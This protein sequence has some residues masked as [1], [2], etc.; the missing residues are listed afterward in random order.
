VKI[1]LIA[2]VLVL[3]FVAGGVVWIGMPRG[4]SLEEVSHLAAPSIERMDAQKVLLVRA[5]GNPNEV[6]KEA[7]GLL[8]KTYYGLPDVPKGGPELQPPRARWPVGEDVAMEDWEGLYAMPVPETVTQ[9]PEGTASGGLTVELAT[10]EYGEVA[11][12]LHVG[13]YDQEE[14]TVD[15]LKAFIESQGYQIS[16]LHEEEYLKGPGMLFMGN[17]DKYLTL[18]RYPV[19]RAGGEGS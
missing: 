1:L 14:E 15:R 4:P 2:A 6:G 17:P 19:E 11:Q 16:G 9:V 7:F 3:A 5:R 8:M 13:R 10:W 12:I 18:I